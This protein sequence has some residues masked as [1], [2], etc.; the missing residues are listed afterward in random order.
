MI[1]LGLGLGNSGLSGTAQESPAW[2]PVAY[3]WA[4][5]AVS[6]G[7]V[8]Q[9][10]ETLLQHQDGGFWPSRAE[11]DS[12]VL[13]EI[14]YAQ[15]RKATR[16]PTPYCDRL[17]PNPFSNFGVDLHP[18]QRMAFNSLFFF[19]RFGFD[20]HLKQRMAFLPWRWTAGRC[21]G[22]PI[23]VRFSVRFRG[24]T[25]PKPD[26]G[27]AQGNGYRISSRGAALAPRRFTP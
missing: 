1:L 14:G 4:V 11:G 27:G 10:W 19:S 21:G 23:R 8:G 12:I 3:R 6:C 7:C 2:V 5:S 25:N 24:E 15:P 26:W 22:P 13:E 16:H 18:K 17:L 9:V 20:L